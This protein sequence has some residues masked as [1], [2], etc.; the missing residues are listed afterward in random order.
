MR[1]HAL[2][3]KAAKNKLAVAEKELAADVPTAAALAVPTAAALD[4]PTAAGPGGGP[5]PAVS[6]E[7]SA[8]ATGEAAEGEG[9][10]TDAA[11]SGNVSDALSVPS[12]LQDGM[13]DAKLK[14]KKVQLKVGG[15]GLQTFESG[16]ALE[17]YMYQLLTSWGELPG[18][19]LAIESKDGKA[20]VFT[21]DDTVARQICDE[22]KAKA[23]ELAD[24]RR[25][26]KKAAKAAAKG[27]NGAEGTPKV[28]KGG[29]LGPN[30]RWCKKCK[31][32]FEGSVCP[33]G[34]AN[35]MFTK[36]IP[37]GAGTMTGEV[38]VAA[39][40]VPSPSKNKRAAGA[41]NALQLQSTRRIL[42]RL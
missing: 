38:A 40:A 30:A 8:T 14:G 7:L 20:A 33:G 9:E 34:H 23:T 1:K 41:C 27:D 18:K 26:Q 25:A 21:C 15:M 31:A 42:L 17:T 36:T 11:V 2:E 12:G 16:R 4:V 37:A 13:Y 6:T 22:M 10:A 32:V 24:S 28:G 5:S 3:L 29:G 35:F 39:A 19:G